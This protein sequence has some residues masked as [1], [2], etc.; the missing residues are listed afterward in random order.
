MKNAALALKYVKVSLIEV[1]FF[2]ICLNEKHD[3]AWLHKIT[4]VFRHS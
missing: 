3:D 4:F 1:N 2:A